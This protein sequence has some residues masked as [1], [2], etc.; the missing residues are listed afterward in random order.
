VEVVLRFLITNLF[1]PAC[2]WKFDGGRVKSIVLGRNPIPIV[3]LMSADLPRFPADWEVF[4]RF[5]VFKDVLMDAKEVWRVSFE[6]AA[7]FGLSFSFRLRV[8]LGWVSVLSSDRSP[9]DCIDLYS[10]FTNMKPNRRISEVLCWAS[11]LEGAD[12]IDGK[13]SNA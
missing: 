10:A 2:G 12:V 13:L 6:L 1:A 9:G 5:E 7:F 3:L 11:F 4:N 8:G